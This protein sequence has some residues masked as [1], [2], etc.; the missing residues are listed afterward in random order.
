MKS[1]QII[2]LVI[3]GLSMAA[4]KKESAV[5]S[6]T[7]APSQQDAVTAGQQCLPGI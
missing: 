6:L 5:Q 3:Y 2:V 4:C 1:H 7:N